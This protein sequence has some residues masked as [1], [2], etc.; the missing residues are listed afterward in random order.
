MKNFVSNFMRK[1][2]RYRNPN[3]SL[4]D[5]FILPEQNNSKMS[6]DVASYLSGNM[7]LPQSLAYFASNLFTP[8]DNFTRNMSIF[9]FNFTLD[10]SADEYMRRFA[11][12]IVKESSSKIKAIDFEDRNLCVVTMHDGKKYQFER[13]NEYF[14]GPVFEDLTTRDRDSKC[15][16]R[17]VVLTRR[18]PK[19]YDSRCVTG[20]VWKESSKIRFL[21]SWVEIVDEDGK[22]KCI[23]N[24]YNMVMDKDLFYLIFHPSIFE[25]IP[26]DTIM[27]DWD[28][29]VDMSERE[30]GL[31]YLKLYCSSRDEAIDLYDKIKTKRKSNEISDQTQVK[32]S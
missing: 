5:R 31:E 2:Q 9:A 13:L 10:E 1:F 25:K 27:K 22:E 24:N 30:D 6:K 29:I 26:K 14:E 20:S 18:L 11:E 32:Q 28:K 7:S 15:H 8:I 19:S 21:H 23:D 12:Y 3:L 4:H 16:P 17:S